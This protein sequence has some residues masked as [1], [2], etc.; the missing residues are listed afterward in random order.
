MEQAEVTRFESVVKEKRWRATWLCSG[1][2]WPP[3]CR[4]LLLTVDFLARRRRSRPCC[5]ASGEA[6]RRGDR[7]RPTVVTPNQHEA[8]G[9][10][11]ARC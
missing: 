3:V 1:A 7:G 10:W 2:A 9:C 11:A 4:S 5:I 8:G 6:L